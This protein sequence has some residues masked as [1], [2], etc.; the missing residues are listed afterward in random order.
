VSLP[1]ALS[2]PC[3]D[4]P[5]R[6]DSTEGWLGPYSARQWID[7]ANSDEAIACHE[8]IQE[9]G[10]WNGAFQCAGAALYRGNVGKLPRDPEVAVMQEPGNDCFI[11]SMEFL[12]HHTDT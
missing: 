9:S 2:K 4:C 12:E 7:L 10:S 1:D 11:S 5:W 8:T 3:N 6:Y